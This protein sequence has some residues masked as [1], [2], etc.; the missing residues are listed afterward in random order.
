MLHTVGREDAEPPVVQ[1]DRAADHER[2]LRK[3]QPLRDVLLH[4]GTRQRLLE[5][6][7]RSPEERGIPFER[8]LGG[9]NVLHPGH[10]RSLGVS[11]GARQA[12]ASRRNHVCVTSKPQWASRSSGGRISLWP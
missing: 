3:P 1:P 9:R 5:L 11:R 6:R 7:E 12:A 8:R 2:A 10:V 4:A